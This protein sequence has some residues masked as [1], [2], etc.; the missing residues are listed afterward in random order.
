MQRGSLRKRSSYCKLTPSSGPE[1][2]SRSRTRRGSEQNISRFR[3]IER[4]SLT[5]ILLQ[6][7]DDS[8]TISRFRLFAIKLLFGL[9]SQIATDDD[10]TRSL[11]RGS[12]RQERP[13]LDRGF[14]RVSYS[15]FFPSSILPRLI[16]TLFISGT[17]EVKVKG[18]ISK[19]TAGNGRTSGSR[20]FF[21]INGRPFHPTKVSE[22]IASSATEN[23]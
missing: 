16:S 2:D 8:P 17:T 10:R 11:A 18:L 13:P 4:K 7:N 12:C 23:T 6:Q 1:L 15:P 5:I 19:P 21:Y 20:Q 22:E 9:R 14:Y 3:G